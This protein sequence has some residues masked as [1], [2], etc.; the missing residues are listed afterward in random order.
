MHPQRAGSPT[1]PD[2][3]EMR[4]RAH[5]VR[6]RLAGGAADGCAVQAPTPGAGAPPE[7]TL[8]VVIVHGDNSE[9]REA[10][11]VG[12]APPGVMK[13]ADGT[14]T[15][16]RSSTTVDGEPLYVHAEGR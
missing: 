13:R 14:H 10:H 4:R 8:F 1:V 7:G 5:T 3:A 15:Y 16:Y 9:D 2:R 11:A 6:A 12:A